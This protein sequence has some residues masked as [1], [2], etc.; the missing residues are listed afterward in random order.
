MHGRPTSR[1]WPL[2]RKDGCATG[3]REAAR[4]VWP[5]AAVG[6][7]ELGNLDCA[8]R[9]AG[10]RGGSGDELLRERHGKEDLWLGKSEWARERRDGAHRD[11]MAMPMGRKTQGSVSRV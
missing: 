11:R 2:G 7:R 6:G 8:E 4:Q 1:A 3:K 5:H 9:A 10:R